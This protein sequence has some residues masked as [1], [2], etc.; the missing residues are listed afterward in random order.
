MINLKPKQH[1]EYYS[2]MYPNAWEHIDQ[3]RVARKGLP[4]WPKWCFIP[5]A[6]VYNVV[7][8]ELEN[9]NIDINEEN[10]LPLLNDVSVIGALAAWRVTQRVYRFD[11]DVYRTVLNTPLTDDLPHNILFNLPEWCVYIETP[12]FNIGGEDL[13]GFFAFMDYDT[14]GKNTELR[15]VFDYDLPIPS[16]YSI[17]IPLG[18]WPLTESITRIMDKV[19]Q[20]MG[21]LDTK[22]TEAMERT[23]EILTSMLSLIMYLCSDN[24][25]LGTKGKRPT[26]PSNKKTP[27]EKPKIWD[28][29]Q[30]TGRTLRQALE[31]AEA[32]TEAQDV[33]EQSYGKA[34]W[35]G[36]WTEPRNGQQK[37]IVKWRSPLSTNSNDDILYH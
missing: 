10:R 3:F 37:F 6:A 1:L 12:G 11:P 21:T 17:P 22:Q 16:L 24:G 27:P 30:K 28:V 19:V 20:Q 25:E 32:P 9:Q 18:P 14:D 7:I 8:S 34:S 23:R 33:S 2:K 29:G 5:L 35:H 4:S 15:L 31:A 36:Y 13:V 26:W